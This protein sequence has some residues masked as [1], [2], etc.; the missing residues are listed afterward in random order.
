MFSNYKQTSPFGNLLVFEV[1]LDDEDDS[2]SMP[3]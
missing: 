1:V 2:E 3:I